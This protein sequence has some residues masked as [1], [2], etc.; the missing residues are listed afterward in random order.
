MFIAP[1]TSLEYGIVASVLVY[2]L[3][4]FFEQLQMYRT[5]RPALTVRMPVGMFRI[6]S[7]LSSNLS[8]LSVGTFYPVRNMSKTH[9]LPAAQTIEKLTNDCLSLYFALL[10]KIS[11]LANP[12]HYPFI[13]PHIIREIHALIP[14]HKD[15]QPIRNIKPRSPRPL[16]SREKRQ[17]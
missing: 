12:H 6:Q 14:L 9:W 1:R 2:L 7:T 11:Q 8:P 3:H 4:A 17:Y 5:A 13:I 16:R 10:R 15:Q